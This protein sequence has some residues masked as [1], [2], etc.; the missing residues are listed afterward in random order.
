MAPLVVSE[1]TIQAKRYSPDPIHFLFLSN[2]NMALLETHH[3][4]K[5]CHGKN[6]LRNERENEADRFQHGKHEI[7][8]HNRK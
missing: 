5:V 8:L 7:E 6:E 2:G 4:R 1:P 3:F